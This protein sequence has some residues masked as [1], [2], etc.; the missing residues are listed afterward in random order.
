MFE[1]I[2]EPDSR[3]SDFYFEN[4]RGYRI[5]HHALGIQVDMYIMTIW[6]LNAV[7][8]LVISI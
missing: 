5:P 2:S 6:I 3:T 4:N 8:D 1:H 7:I